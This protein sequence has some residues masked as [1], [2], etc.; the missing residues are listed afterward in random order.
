M[1]RVDRAILQGCMYVRTMMY[2]CTLSCSVCMY[3]FL[4]TPNYNISLKIY[5]SFLG[6]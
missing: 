3:N 1:G 6:M 4:R 5:V 2:Y